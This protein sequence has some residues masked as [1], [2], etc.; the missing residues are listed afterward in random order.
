[1]VVVV[2]DATVEEVEN[3]V[4]FCQSS[5]KDYDIYLY[6]N[7]I[8]DLQWLNLAVSTAN[9]TLISQTSSVTI[10]NTSQLSKFGFEQQLN[11][12]LAYFQQVDIL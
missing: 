8:D 12:P 11:T 7:D 2:I 5:N 3:I 1:M 9:Y 4:L 6:S 10:D